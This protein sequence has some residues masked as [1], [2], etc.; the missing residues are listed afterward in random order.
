ML[1]NISKA[2]EPRSFCK[3]TAVG[4]SSDKIHELHVT[5]SR[6]ALL[7]FAT[8]LMG[9]YEGMGDDEKCVVETHPLVKDPAPGAS[10]GFWLTPHSPELTLRING[11]DADYRGVVPSFSEIDIKDN[12]DRYYNIP[13][14]LDE[15]EQERNGY[16]CI[17]AYEIGKRNL[18]NID[19]IDNNGADITN[20]ISAIVVDLP[21]RG[22][23]DFATMLF[24]WADNVRDNTDYFLCREGSSE[25]GY[26]FGVILTEDSPLVKFRVK[27]LGSKCDCEQKQL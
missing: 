10:V 8:E 17:S 4:P 27:D 9:L 24:V 26:N 21:R 11:A 25:P 6:E 3:V 13:D 22:M 12:Y 7:G 23:N 5:F 20:Q 18:V 14:S 16:L 1:I 15:C 19:A 2:V